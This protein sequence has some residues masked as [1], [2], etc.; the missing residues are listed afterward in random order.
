MVILIVWVFFNLLEEK[1]KLESSEKVFENKDFCDVVMSSKNTKI[2]EFNQY[3][4][5]TYH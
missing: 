3:L 4:I 1:N 2:L 5:N